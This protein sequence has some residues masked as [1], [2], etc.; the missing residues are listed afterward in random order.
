MQEQPQM[1][2]TNALPTTSGHVHA[3][4]KR[5]QVYSPT[6]V[7]VRVS[8]DDG[9]NKGRAHS[10]GFDVVGTRKQD[11]TSREYDTIALRDSFEIALKRLEAAADVDHSLR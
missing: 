10:H 7:R 9:G 5:V 2:P 4:N 6:H 1:S 3:A 11:V 8:M